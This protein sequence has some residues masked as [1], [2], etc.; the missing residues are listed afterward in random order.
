MG[1]SERGK[2]VGILLDPRHKVRP[3]RH[4]VAATVEQ[5]PPSQWTR[6][7]SFIHVLG[8]RWTFCKL[9]EYS[10]LPLAARRRAETRTELASVLRLAVQLPTYDQTEADA[11]RLTGPADIPPPPRPSMEDTGAAELDASQQPP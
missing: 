7:H 3:V 8:D 5:P 9:P 11:P 2:Y 10:G 6:F 4:S 1:R